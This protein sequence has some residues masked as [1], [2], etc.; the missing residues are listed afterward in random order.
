MRQST[1]LASLTVENGKVYSVFREYFSARIGS[2]ST[3]F[4]CKMN[5]A[6]CSRMCQNHERRYGF[7]RAL[8][9]EV[10]H[11]FKFVWNNNM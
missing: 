2:L 10:I 1:Q 6:M 4:S 9:M 5:L 8:I 3:I 7:K 11:Y